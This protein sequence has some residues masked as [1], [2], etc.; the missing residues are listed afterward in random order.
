MSPNPQNT[1]LFS[2]NWQVLNYLIM[3]GHL[4]VLNQCRVYES[5]CY[6]RNTWFKVAK[7]AKGFITTSRLNELLPG[8]PLMSFY[9]N[10]ISSY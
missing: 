2:F 3:W 6:H 10:V 1:I 5:A 8:D 9:Y 4:I 7:A